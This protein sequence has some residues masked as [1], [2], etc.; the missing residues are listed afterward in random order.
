MSSPSAPYAVDGPGA[1]HSSAESL[2]AGAGAGP[3]SSSSSSSSSTTAALAAARGGVYI[4]PFRQ[5]RMMEELAKA[6][7]T[8]PEYQRVAW[9]ALR[10]GI[11]GVVNKVNSSNIVHLLPELF[12]INLVRGRGLL[13]RAVLK[14][15]LTSPGFT[16]VYAALVAV[17]NT[18]LPE[19]GELL[20]RRVVSQ[21]RRAFKRRNKLVSLGL[22]KFLAHLVNTQVA[23]EVVAL[24]VLALL[25]EQPTDDSVE[26]AVAFAK[27]CGAMLTELA[28]QA[29]HAVFERFRHILAEGAVDVRVAYVVEGLFT[30]RKARFADFPPVPPEL[31]LVESEEQ[32]THEVG[33]EDSCDTEDM[34]DVFKVDT[35]FEAHEAAWD[36]IKR[37]IL[38]DGE[39]DA[40]DNGGGG[41]GAG[42][43][44]GGGGGSA[45]VDGERDEDDIGDAA[46]VDA[47]ELAEAMARN[48]GGGAGAGSGGG[49][50]TV[51]G[52]GFSSSSSSSAPMEIVDLSE[53][54][55]VNLRRTIY[56]TIMSSVD[57]EECAHKLLKMSI[58]KGAEV[59]LC[60]M[61][62]ECCSQ[63]R[64]FLRYYGLL[65]QRFCN[66][67]RTYQDRFEECFAQQY[68]TIHRLETNKI[69][70]VS[71]FFALLLYTDALPWTV[72]EHIRLTETDTTPSSRI[73]VKFLFQELA[74]YMGLAKL[75]DRAMD[76][77]MA[78]IFGGLFPRDSLRNTRFAINFFTSI[79][80]GALTDDLRA[81]LKQKMAEA[82][83]E[84]GAGAGADLM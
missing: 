2:G 46:V 73:F 68:G 51:M 63:E 58:P 48:S 65:G 22:A 71:K 42:A 4:P 24:Q 74:E 55:L 11:N 38:G 30:A 69:R 16:P 79:G 82:E 26:V 17:I 29:T 8:S 70:N 33:L 25:L 54:D 44:A 13:C 47:G 15:Q 60:N 57:F 36:E 14:A 9:E 61:L 78:D 56:L 10:K 83:A 67:S 72:F 21:F 64:T 5:R 18:K 50:G 20:L 3:S 27:E 40:A 80:L 59:E 77:Y 49:A 32:I 28:P 76:A 19:I 23:H 39:A 1:G 45:S 53:T 37:E 66:I 81:F 62:I 12:A 84:G 43:G 52:S 35:E 6:D 41:A 31:D 75:R 34:L 7:K